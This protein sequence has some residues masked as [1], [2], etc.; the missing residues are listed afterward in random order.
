MEVLVGKSSI[1]GLF[2]MAMLNKQ[3]VTWE[4][5]RFNANNH[6]F[7]LLP[8]LIVLK[9]EQWSKQLIDARNTMK[10]Q[11][12]LEFCVVGAESKEL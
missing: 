5:S 8:R 12:L 11:I 1:N 9:A 6:R 7:V 2:S 10:T 3:R 4:G